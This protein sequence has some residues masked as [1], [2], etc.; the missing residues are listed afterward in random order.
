MPWPM[1]SNFSGTRLL[2]VIRN[3]LC[4]VGFGYAEN[5]S[6][7]PVDVKT[8]GVEYPIGAEALSSLPKKDSLF[9]TSD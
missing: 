4:G 5:A 8:G 2:L 7:Y 3:S 6:P 9:V 1:V